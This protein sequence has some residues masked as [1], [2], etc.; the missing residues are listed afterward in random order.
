MK[1]S[2]VTIRKARALITGIIFLVCIAI[3]Y[4]DYQCYEK[5]SLEATDD[6]YMIEINEGEVRWNFTLDPQ[7]YLLE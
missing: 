1:L 4:C 7:F 6:L 3:V 2:S 5:I